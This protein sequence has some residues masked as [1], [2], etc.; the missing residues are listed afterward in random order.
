MASKV[1][2]EEQLNYFRV[3]HI[4]TDILPQAL[5][6]LFKQE[7]DNYYKA[8]LG[9][10]KDRPQNGLDFKNGESPA[11]QRR[12]A[13][14]L[15]TMVNGDRAE[16]DCTML[17]YAI[18]FSDSIGHRL[19]PLIKTNVD[20]LRK[21]RNEDF[22]HM[23]EGQF[24]S[25][26]F[27][28]TVAK[29]ETAFRALGLSTVEI[30]T[31][32]NQ[33]SFPTDELQNV[34]TSNQKLTQDLR[35]KALEL[36]DKDTKLQDKTK[37]LLGK[38]IEFQE[39][40]VK[41]E[42]KEA[43]LQD[44][45]KTT[46]QQ[47][48]VF[49]EQLQ[50]KV[51]PFCVLPPRPS[52]VIASRDCHVDKVTQKLLKLRKANENTISYCYISGNPGSGKS[53][54]AGLVA[55]KYYKEASKETNAPSFVMTLNAENP[56]ALLT[57][58]LSLARK[59][60]CPECT[61]NATENSKDLNNERKIAI[62]KDLIATKIHLYSSWLLVIDNV[63]NLSWIGQFLPEWGNEHWSKG[64]LLI[65]TQ[66]CSC[67]PPDSSFTSH[68]SISK[69]MEPA[70]AICLLT[71]LSGITDNDMGENVAHALDYQPL[72]LASA[73]VYVRKV[74]NTNPNFGW[75]GYLE[76][77][78]KG[79]RELTEKEL[80]NV[81]SIYPNS[82]TVAT[83]I[84]LETVM[85]SDEIM[86]HAFT[87]LAFCA[88]EP[89]RLDVLTTYVVNADGELDEEDI[90]I[91]IQGSSLLLIEKK[92]V[93]N[94]RLHKVVHNIVERLVKDQMEANEH[95]RVACV[96]IGSCSQYIHKA[97]PEILQGEDSVCRSRHIV[98]HL[99]TL[100]VG[101]TN[102]ISTEEKFGLIKNTILNI[103]NSIDN[104]EML[105]HVCWSHSE[106]VSAMK[107]FSVAL[108]LIEDN[109]IRTGPDHGHAKRV[110]RIYHNIGLLHRHLSDYQQA[111]EYF[112]RALSIQ[113]NTLGPDHV[114]VARTYHNMGI[115]HCNL[116]NNQQA[117]KYCE[118]ALSIRLNK[119]GPDHVDVARTCHNM[120]NVHRHLG[121]NQQAKK[122]YE[123]ALSIQLNKLGPD[124]VDVAAT[125]HNMGILHNKLGGYQQS[126]EYYER[127]LS[128]KLNKLGPDHVNVASTYRNMGSLH[129][130]LG[131]NQQAKKYYE[132]ALFIQ[133]NKLGPN[134]VGVAS[135]CLDMGNLHRNLGDNQQAKE[136]YQRALYITL[137]KLGPDHAKVTELSHLLADV[138][139]V[140]DFQQQAPDHHDRTQLN[141]PQKR[142]PDQTDFEFANCKRRR[143]DR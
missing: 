38:D 77:L 6:L 80:A 54:L 32:R 60:H 48:K 125:Y 105:S 35:T 4:A 126:K 42:G 43:E 109:T 90:G 57:S 130:V 141:Q 18:L 127:A 112:E 132:R 99:K 102:I 64:Q 100:A 20:D 45:L 22:A 83:K 133:L 16:W 134:H 34:T 65:T 24:S 49:E 53:Q 63:T 82:M 61:I 3:C 143:V 78:E 2:S 101:I 131:D 137:N 40:K 75:E 87:F 30:E 44:R 73:G 56:E 123:R 72:A 116:G 91:Q 50:R 96:A 62:I 71:E 95:A 55:E 118:R 17:F 108:K 31:V 41:F 128:I 110:S 1:Y 66:D 76:K 21:F 11:N 92:D 36:Q 33:K 59:M 85:D 81:N 139:R 58:Y 104:F 135:T 68:I 13:R 51:E 8:T 15:A 111:K 106:Y 70:D 19:S 124:H 97:I 37:E 26:D 103:H 5:R 136:Y 12:K 120:G 107:Y 39:E 129:H 47:R 89:L 23:T 113:L 114:D 117:K 69:G 29:V 94:I 88:P 115:L 14:L 79:K 138:Q 86:K 74:R 142:T 98:P 52:H 140:L 122:Y 84:A 10:W 7:W 46:E 119:L 67:I 121:D 28:I 9:E 25:A 27:R 93:V